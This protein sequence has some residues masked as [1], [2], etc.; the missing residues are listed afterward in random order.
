MLTFNED[1]GQINEDMAK[2]DKLLKLF[3][4]EDIDQKSDEGVEDFRKTGVEDFRKTIDSIICLPGDKFK[5]LNEYQQDNNNRSFFKKLFSKKNSTEELTIGKIYENYISLA[6]IV[7][8]L[9]KFANT[10]VTQIESFGMP[11]SFCSYTYIGDMEIRV[12]S[13]EILRVQCTNEPVLVGGDYKEYEN[14]KEQIFDLA[15]IRVCYKVFTKLIKDRNFIINNGVFFVINDNNISE[16]NYPTFKLYISNFGTIE[17]SMVDR[18]LKVN[19]FSID[20]SIDK[21]LKENYVSIL[22]SCYIEKS[23]ISDLLNCFD[24][25][26][27]TVDY[28]SK[29]K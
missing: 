1:I 8:E 27:E 25:L 20:I 9:F 4:N 28:I 19:S 14:I 7:N 17:I 23:S 13:W 26:K 11:V 22:S 2:M 10:I 5:I 16:N 12:G 29:S 3:E 6:E 18:K 15:R 21:Y 24:N